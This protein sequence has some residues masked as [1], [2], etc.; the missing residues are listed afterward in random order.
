MELIY[1]TQKDHTDNRLVLFLL[2]MRSVRQFESLDR[3]K[4]PLGGTG[5]PGRHMDPDGQQSDSGRGASDEDLS[6]TLAQHAAAQAGLQTFH[7]GCPAA[8]SGGTLRTRH[9]MAG[10]FSA[11]SSGASATLGPRQLSVARQCASPSEY[12]RPAAAPNAGSGG[13]DSY[14]LLRRRPAAGAAPSGVGGTPG[15]PPVAGSGR[16]DAEQLVEEIDQLFF[17]DM[18]L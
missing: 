5:P 12:T 16:V 13:S 6:A 15:G 9:L 1:N 18:M 10:G 8:G 17:K 3:S 4:A 14:E 7:P 11:P 2:Q